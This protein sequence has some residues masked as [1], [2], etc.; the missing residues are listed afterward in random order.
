MIVI[1]TSAILAYMDSADSHH[2]EITD[3]LDGE[4]DELV[5]TPLIV[6]EADHMVTVRGGRRAAAG[7]HADL[8]SGAY[9]V[10]WWPAALHTSVEIAERYADAGLGLADASLV[11]LAERVGTVRVATFDERHFRS[12]RPLSGGESFQLL[13]TDRE[14]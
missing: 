13:P 4:L 11:A 14:T 6:A 7:L 8:V 10:D 2:G 1:D 12:L 5:T 3:W 9:L